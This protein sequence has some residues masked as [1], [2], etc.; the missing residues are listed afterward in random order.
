VSLQALNDANKDYLAALTRRDSSK[1][2]IGV[3]T[4]KLRQ[5]KAQVL[6][7]QAS[8]KQLTEQLGIRRLLRR[9]MERFCRAM[10]RLAMR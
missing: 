6:Q 4:A 10:W 7:S 9:W 5:A 2:Q 3:D 8:L 1:A